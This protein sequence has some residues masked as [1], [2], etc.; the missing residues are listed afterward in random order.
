[1][2]DDLDDTARLVRRAAEL[3]A[4]AAELDR[5]ILHHLQSLSGPDTWV[6]P[7]ATWFDDVALG[8]ARA[9]DAARDDLHAAARR[10]ELRAAE[11]RVEH[12]ARVLLA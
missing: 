5:S 4:V 1:M 7:T 10:L 6:G 2:A 12:A 9:A 8:A 3:R 11:L